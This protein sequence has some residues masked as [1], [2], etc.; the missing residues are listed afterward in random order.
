LTLARWGLEALDSL[1]RTPQLSRQRI[2][3]LEAAADASD[4]LGHRE[5]QRRWL[6]ALS[7]LNLS[8]ENDREEV[9]RVYLLHGRYA[10]VRPGAGIPA[11]SG[12]ALGGSADQRP[13]QRVAAAPRGGADPRR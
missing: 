10:S 13:A 7:D 3:F 6:D 11:P 8:P 2:A 1:P 12:R 5:A 4:R 9:V